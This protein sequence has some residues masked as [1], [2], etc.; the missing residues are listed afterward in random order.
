[1]VDFEK[2]GESNRKKSIG[3]ATRISPNSE[4]CLAMK[5]LLILLCLVAVACDTPGPTPIDY[6]S[7]QC[8]HCK[9]TISDRKFGAE[10]ISVKGKTYKFD[11]PE[12]M[13]GSYTQESAESKSNVA[14]LW[15][16]NYNN[17]GELINAKYAYYLQ[18]REFRTPMGLNAAAF[19][20]SADR[21]RAMSKFPGKELDFDHVVQLA[22]TR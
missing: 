5:R 20:T 18:N 11:S 19:K 2:A 22:A 6:G 4:Y 13:I 14:S 15:V 12:C 3:E 9:M 10:I 16:T 8:T 7:D 17:P 1:M 21:A